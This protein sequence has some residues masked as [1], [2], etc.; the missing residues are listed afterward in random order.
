MKHQIYK[1]KNVFITGHSGFKGS[2]LAKWLVSLGANVTGYSLPAEEL[3]HF[4]LLKLP[5]KSYFEN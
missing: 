1:N 3:S 4:N 5:M 2:W